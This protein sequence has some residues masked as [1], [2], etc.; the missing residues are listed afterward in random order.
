M[1]AGCYR[2]GVDCIGKT[3]NP[4]ILNLVGLDSCECAVVGSETD[5]EVFIQIVRDSAY[6][7]IGVRDMLKLDWCPRSFRSTDDQST[8][9]GNPM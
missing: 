5:A 3:C 8:S 2:L 9:S 1:S 6:F 4:E 7:S